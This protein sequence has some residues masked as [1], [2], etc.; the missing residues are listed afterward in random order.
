MVRSAFYLLMSV[1]E[2]GHSTLINGCYWDDLQK[3]VKFRLIYFPIP[4]LQS[5]VEG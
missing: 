2:P 3:Y 4:Y 5:S 1:A